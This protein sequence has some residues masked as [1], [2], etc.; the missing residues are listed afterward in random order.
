MPVYDKS[1]RWLIQKYLVDKFSAQRQGVDGATIT[2]D[3]VSTDP[4]TE[5]QRQEGKSLGIYPTVEVT[6]QIIGW[7]QKHVTM[8]FEFNLMIPDGDSPSETL[9]AALAEVQKIVFSD[10][11]C[12]GLTLDINEKASEIDIGNPTDRIAKGALAVSVFYRHRTGN[13]FS[14]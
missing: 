5:N 10:T 7:D 12:G 8:V 3:F 11:N 2:W 9:E 4:L 13:P 14:A 1:V 6:K